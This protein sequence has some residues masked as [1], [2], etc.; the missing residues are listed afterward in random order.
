MIYFLI[1]YPVFNPPDTG[2]I[3]LE[4][5]GGFKANASGGIDVVLGNHNGGA[6]SP[7][8]DTMNSL[9]NQTR[10]QA[11]TLS[12]ITQTPMGVI[13]E[14]LPTISLR[15]GEMQLNYSNP[16]TKRACTPKT[17]AKS[18]R[19]Y[20]RRGPFCLIAANDFAWSVVA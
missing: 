1:R 10:L 4:A 5:D 6:N 19:T 3:R 15:P 20:C 2:L 13:A 18:P 17:I 7:F 11:Q 8:I 12:D 14:R 9:L 16:M